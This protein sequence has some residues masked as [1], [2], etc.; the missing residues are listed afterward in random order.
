MFYLGSPSCSSYCLTIFTG[1][2]INTP[3]TSNNTALMTSDITPRPTIDADLAVSQ[4]LAGNMAELEYG[5]YSICLYPH[6]SFV[7]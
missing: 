7:C 2:D 5:G 1:E 3:P 4:R 6:V